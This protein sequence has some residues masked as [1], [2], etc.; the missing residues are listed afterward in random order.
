MCDGEFRQVDVPMEG[1]ETV[2]EIH[3]PLASD[4]IRD[5]D[6]ADF[7]TLKI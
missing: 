2:A 1:L 3:G 4:I 7:A 6:I 5:L